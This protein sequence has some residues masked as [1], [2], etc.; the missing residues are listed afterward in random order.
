[1]SE[2]RPCHADAFAIHIKIG[3]ES[4]GE[5]ICH[6]VNHGIGGQGL[7]TLDPLMRLQFKARQ[8]RHLEEITEEIPAYSFL[9]QCQLKVFIFHR[10]EQMTSH[11]CLVE[12][13]C[14]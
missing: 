1:M 13:R 5:E 11:H 14:D 7:T 6:Q 10:V 12:V 3:T 9:D 2:C 8:S 4:L